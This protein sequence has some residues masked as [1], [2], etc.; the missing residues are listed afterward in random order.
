MSKYFLLSLL[1]FVLPAAAQQI[2][3]PTRPLGHSYDAGVV[4]TGTGVQLT[5][6]LVSPNRKLAIINGQT[7]RELQTVKGLGAIV[8]KIDADA[9]TLQQGDKVWRVALSNTAVRK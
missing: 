7:V 9:V 4:S 8:K 2:A 5:S 1:M 3:D 6:I